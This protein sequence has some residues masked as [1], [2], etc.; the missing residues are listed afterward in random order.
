MT[1][2]DEGVV[3][4]SRSV[5][6]GEPMPLQVTEMS[7]HAQ[8]DA[9]VVTLSVEKFWVLMWSVTL[10]KLREA[11]LKTTPA[12]L[13]VTDPD[14]PTGTRQPQFPEAPVIGL[15]CAPLKPAMLTPASGVLPLVTVPLTEGSLGQ[16]PKSWSAELLSR[17]WVFALPDA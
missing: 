10:L 14:Q 5:E 15:H 17:T 2:V 3:S 1:L 13:G 4:T 6:A 8:V 11:G 16:S 12:L 9:G 7:H